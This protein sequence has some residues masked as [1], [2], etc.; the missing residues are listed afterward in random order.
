MNLII[1]LKAMLEKAKNQ[2]EK[3]LK[4]Y[5]SILNPKKKIKIRGI[6]NHLL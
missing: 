4:K 5:H 6:K 3:T 2:A 1:Q